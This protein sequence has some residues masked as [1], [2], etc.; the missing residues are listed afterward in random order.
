ML[1]SHL[2]YF[3]SCLAAVHDGHIDVHHDELDGTICSVLLE[4]LQVCFQGLQ[5][6]VGLDDVLLHV[7]FENLAH[8][9]LQY[10]HIKEHV[11]NYE[12]AGTQRR[13]TN[14]LN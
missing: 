3:S 1:G 8:H 14:L 12:Y 4:Q 10:I 6:I 2:E 13:L 9:I 7:H 11:I 5:A